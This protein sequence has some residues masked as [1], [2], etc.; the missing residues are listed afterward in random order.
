M[1]MEHDIA[2]LNR[3]LNRSNATPLTGREVNSINASFKAAPDEHDVFRLSI[4]VILNRNKEL[5][6]L[7]KANVLRAFLNEIEKPDN[8]A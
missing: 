7:G 2:A 3:L 6:L 4:N 1:L 8:H 5:T